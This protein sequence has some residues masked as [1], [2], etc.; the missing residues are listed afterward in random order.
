MGTTCQWGRSLQSCSGI[1]ATPTGH[2]QNKRSD[3]T[4]MT[5]TTADW[6][7]S[8]QGNTPYAASF[9]P[10]REFEPT[11]WHTSRRE[12]VSIKIMIALHLNLHYSIAS[13]CACGHLLY[14]SL[15]LISHPTS[16][17]LT[18]AHLNTLQGNV[19][20][21]KRAHLDRWDGCCVGS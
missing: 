14:M 16:C 10:S 21:G 17:R 13:T 9:S 6:S 12:E 4:I 11:P 5:K 1:S 7:L 2:H 20:A 15:F 8:M 3:L 19:T 18:G